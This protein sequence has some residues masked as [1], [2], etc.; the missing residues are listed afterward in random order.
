MSSL[1]VGMANPPA[2]AKRSVW[3]VV[4]R[5][6]VV[7]VALAVIGFIALNLL[8]RA[9]FAPLPDLERPEGV[10]SGSLR[11]IPYADPT[12]VAIRVSVSPQAVTAAGA[13]DGLVHLELDVARAGGGSI[14]MEVGIQQPGQVNA[15]R[16]LSPLEPGADVR[17]TLHCV[18]GEPCEHIVDLRFGPV[19]E[20]ATAVVVEW[21][22]VV[23]VRPPRGTDVSEDATVSLSLV[24][25]SE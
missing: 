6:I 3:A 17:W 13:G 4:G 20:Q 24:E 19:R 18:T 5:I 7:L 23:D 11:V 21:R 10:L 9:A 22:L 12:S 16:R 25:A 1:E 14:P 2:R 15:V 8:F